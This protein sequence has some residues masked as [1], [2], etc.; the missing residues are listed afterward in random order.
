MTPQEAWD[1][2][3]DALARTTP[4]CS[5][6]LSPCAATVILAEREAAAPPAEG[7]VTDAA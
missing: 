7:E 1:S 5:V 3:R 2:L 4:G 6:V